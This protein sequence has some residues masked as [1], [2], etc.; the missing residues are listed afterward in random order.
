MRTRAVLGSILGSA[1][2]LFVGWQAG[3]AIAPAGVSSSLGSTPV[4]TAPGVNSG[5]ASGSAPSSS[6][7]TPN[8]NPAGGASSGASGTFTGDTAQT[9]FGPMQVAIVVSGGKVTDVKTLQVTNMGGRSA[10]ISNYAT[11][12]LKQ[13]VLAAQSSQV[14]MVSGATYTSQG[15]LT[16]LQSALDKAKI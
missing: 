14:N 5:T 8:T 7:A 9:P 12:I 13:E 11:P 10:Q 1:A 4:G 15:Y 3:A 6:G 2:V 16:S